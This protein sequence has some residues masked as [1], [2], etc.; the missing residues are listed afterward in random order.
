MTRQHLFK[1]FSFFASVD[2]DV[3]ADAL[4]SN[5]LSSTLVL[6]FTRC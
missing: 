5:T 1:F 2:Q 6:L 3:N 4:G